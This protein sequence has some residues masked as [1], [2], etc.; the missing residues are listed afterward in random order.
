MENPMIKYLHSHCVHR[1]T[2]KKGVIT[3]VPERAISTKCFVEV[4]YDDGAME[5]EAFDCLEIPD[6]ALEIKFLYGS[7][8]KSLTRK[9]LEGRHNTDDPTNHS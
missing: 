9:I 3:A 7:M 6:H 4:V 1:I 8:T 5:I 2:H